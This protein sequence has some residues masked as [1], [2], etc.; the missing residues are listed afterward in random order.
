MITTYRYICYVLA[1]S[2]L[3]SGCSATRF[4]DLFSS[5]YQQMQ[6][7]KTA[8]SQ[9]KYQQ[10]LK[11]LPN[12]SQSNNAYNLSLLE[13]GRLQFLAKQIKPSQ[14]SLAHAYQ[15]ISDEQEK[16][17]IQLSRGVENAA[18]IVSN[19]SATRYIVPPYEQTMLHSYQALNYLSE[20]KLSSALVEVRRANLV[21]EQALR[22]NNAKL[23]KAEQNMAKHGV[24]MNSLSS[25]YPSMQ[26]TIGEVKNGFQNAYTFYLSG[27]LY[28]AGGQK[29]DAYI[30]Y[31]KALEIFPDN[32]ILQQEVWRLANQLSMVD[33]IARYK[34]SFN[35]NENDHKTNSGN[36][37][38]I[39][40]HGIIENK[41]EF[42]L[43]LPIFTSHDDMRFYSFSVPTYKNYLRNYAPVSINYQG[44][45]YQSEEIVRLQSLAAFQLKEQMPATIARQIARIIAKEEIRQQLSRKGGD[46]GNILAGLYNITTEQADTRSWSTLP[47]KVEIMKLAL[48]PGQHKIELDIGGAKKAVEVTINQQANTLLYVTAI[49]SQ[50]Q[51]RVFN[52]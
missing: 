48:A 47:D 13:H 14:D 39:T 34:Q 4:N 2:I 42:S 21:Q 30:D 19:D 26:T 11:L 1:S 33:D 31:K 46:V 27:L 35:I 22:S 24:S 18:A 5:Y 28:E 20:N 9:G 29:N 36:L 52:L 44:K 49:G 32:S 8:Q 16:A 7:V 51:L 37:I 38:V 17:K 6:P 45:H 12:R 25:K 3:L 23:Y 15:V 40:E 43:N 41:S 50:S 10:A